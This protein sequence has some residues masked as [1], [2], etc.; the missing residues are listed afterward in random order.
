VA[1]RDLVGLTVGALGFSSALAVITAE[2]HVSGRDPGTWA[3]KKKTNWELRTLRPFPPR[4]PIAALARAII[5]LHREYVALPPETS[6][7]PDAKRFGYV[8][9]DRGRTSEV[10]RG[11][12]DHL[13]GT[14]MSLRCSPIVEESSTQIPC[15]RREDLLIRLH[16]GVDEDIL[17]VPESYSDAQEHLLR[18]DTQ[19]QW[20]VGDNDYL[21]AAIALAYWWAPVPP[22][23]ERREWIA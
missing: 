2:D 4:T 1:R 22:G 3:P 15:I 9:I 21:A 7:H 19:Q 13:R 14:G 10:A 16:R 23:G 17:N 20:R 5:A 18:I 11:L 6:W 12:W 8:T